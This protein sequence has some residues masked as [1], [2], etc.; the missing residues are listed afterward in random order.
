MSE[1]RVVFETSTLVSAALRPDSIPHQALLKAFRYFTVC[2]SKETLEELREVLARDKFSRY[3]NKDIREQFIRL[4]ESNA[5]LFIVHELNWPAVGIRCRDPKDD[6]F[7]A[8]AAECEASILVS[9]DEDLLVLH[10]WN[11]V[12]IVRPAGFLLEGK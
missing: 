5:R 10:P 12:R 11:G 9:S 1:Q 4:I 8:L 6:K 3:L 7:L 2:V